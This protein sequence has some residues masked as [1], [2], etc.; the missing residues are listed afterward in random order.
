ML[1][2][3]MVGD[4]WNG[5]IEVSTGHV[6]VIKLACLGRAIALAYLYYSGHRSRLAPMAVEN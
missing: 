3:D 4:A 1:W 5:E 2:V 6:D